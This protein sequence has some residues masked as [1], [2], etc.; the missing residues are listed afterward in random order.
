M[1]KSLV[2][3]A[4]QLVTSKYK[5]TASE[6][7]IV[8]L[9]ASVINKNDDDL[10]IHRF[11][12][13]D[14]VRL[15]GIGDRNYSELQN[16]TR[17]LMQRVLEIQEGN[18]LVQVS[19]LSL[20]IYNYSEGTVDMRFDPALKPYLL[21]LKESFIKYRLENILQLK[22]FYS[23][24]FYELLV[25]WKK[26]GKFAVS[27]KELRKLFN[28][29]PKKYEKYNDLKKRIITK[30]QLE[31][32]E[33]TDLY[34]EFKEIK[35]GRKI[36]HIE[37]EIK[38]TGN[39]L[40]ETDETLIKPIEINSETI[41]NEKIL[42]KLKDIGLSESKAKTLISTYSEERIENQL[43]Y[44][45]Y[46]KAK[47]R[48]AVLIKSVEENWSAP[49]KYLEENQTDITKK[50]NSE[51]KKEESLEKQ[52][53]TEELRKQS[54]YD[55]YQLLELLDFLESDIER[56]RILFEGVV[57]KFRLSKNMGYKLN[58]E[59]AIR[60]NNGKINFDLLKKPHFRWVIWQDLLDSFPEFKCQS[61]EE[62][63]ST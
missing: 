42:E 7:K 23:I 12:A 54:E 9:L 40:L 62:W 52:R 55:N 43:E 61:Y 59:T 46:R 16:I 25:K 20:T 56:S 15:T 5:L 47:S 19:F 51:K 24:R 37:F 57:N 17:N 8:T 60:S 36:T 28:L 41:T 38:T 2:V 33:K 58:T 13:K 4:N 44:L 30:A 48:S 50:L 35:T 21:N 22:S 1:S 45:P 3:K 6:A 26:V 32:K 14:L 10:K 18:R 53:E 49:D 34:F 39:Q 63:E 27:I 31:L 29:K 11:K